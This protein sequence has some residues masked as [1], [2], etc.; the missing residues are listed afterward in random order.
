M[1]EPERQHEP[2]RGRILGGAPGLRPVRIGPQVLVDVTAVIVDHVIGR[3]DLEKRG[4]WQ[5]LR[6][7]IGDAGVRDFRRRQRANANARNLKRGDSRTGF[8]VAGAAF[9][10]GNVL[11]AAQFL[12][13]V[14]APHAVA[15]EGGALRQ[16]AAPLS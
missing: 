11:E 2:A 8:A 5:R 15:R 16:A 7:S 9:G 4:L 13:R 14:T 3:L 6:S 12:A 10:F 1:I